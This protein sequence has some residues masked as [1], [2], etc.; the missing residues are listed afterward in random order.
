MCILCEET[1]CEAKAQHALLINGKMGKGLSGGS[2]I[3]HGK[4]VE[5][6]AVLDWSRNP[7]VPL[8]LQAVAQFSKI[9]LAR[10][11][12]ADAI[13]PVSGGDNCN[14]DLLNAPEQDSR[15]WGRGAMQKSIG[16]REKVT[17]PKVQRAVEAR[18]TNCSDE[19]NKLRIGIGFNKSKEE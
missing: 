15:R 6:F 16:K 3:D 9:D 7:L 5:I 18:L 8:P 10:V 19:G 14:P 12:K 2:H 4:A 17:R 13:L 1:A 11:E